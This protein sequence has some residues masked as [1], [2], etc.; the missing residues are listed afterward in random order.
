MLH[1]SQSNAVPFELRVKPL[2]ALFRPAD[3]VKMTIWR[4]LALL[5]RDKYVYRKMAPTVSSHLGPEP[6]GRRKTGSCRS[7]ADIYVACAHDCISIMTDLQPSA[8]DTS[9]H[10]CSRSPNADWS[11]YAATRFR[12]AFYNPDVSTLSYVRLV[13]ALPDSVSSGLWAA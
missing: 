3:F 5:G 9:S 7:I 8:G 12:G 6:T 2:G 11:R 1:L 13:C 10:F 4:R